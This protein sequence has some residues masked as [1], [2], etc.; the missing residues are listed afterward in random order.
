MLVL[1][2]IFLRIFI[3]FIILAFA[4]SFI[5]N[6]W[7]YVDATTDPSALVEQGEYVT[8]DGVDLFFLDKGT[9]SDTFVL[10]H[11][12]GFSSDTWHYI[13]DDLSRYGRV[14]AYDMAGFGYSTKGGDIDYSLEVR[15]D[16]LETFLNL[17]GA[18]DVTLVGHGY[19]AKIAMVYSMTHNAYVNDLILISPDAYTKSRWPGF[20]FTTPEISKAGYKLLNSDKR[21]QSRYTDMFVNASLVTQEDINRFIQ[22]YNTQGAEDAYL[23]MYRV[24][25]A[26]QDYS[27]VSRPTLILYGEKD[28]QV[29]R[30]DMERLRADTYNAR[31]L[32]LENV[33]HVPQEEVP[34]IIKDQLLTFISDPTRNR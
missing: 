27:K 23:R 10:I 31:V 29:D 17:V 22:P 30:V 33:G 3:I 20:L 24:K 15:V 13:F 34:E 32:T 1:A 2:K 8:V 19:G 6:R 4:F 9:G 12:Y 21:L 28:Q 16:R 25:D 26:R 5:Y 11:D 18:K 7:V 14:I